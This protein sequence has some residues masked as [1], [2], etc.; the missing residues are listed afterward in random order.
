MCA[1]LGN[2][3]VLFLANHGVIVTGG[4]VAEAFD[5]LYYLERAAMIQVLAMST[6]RP[7]K[8]IPEPMIEKTVAQFAREA[9]T[10]TLQHLEAIKRIL[11][12]EAPEYRN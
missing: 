3:Q 6:G 5:R 12:R 8:R 9:G 11:D 4:S 2:R 7:L 1:A 10:Q